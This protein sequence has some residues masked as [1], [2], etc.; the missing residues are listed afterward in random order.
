MKKYV[1]R[2]QKSTKIKREGVE[3]K[4]KERI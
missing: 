1:N 4:K 3:L 2:L